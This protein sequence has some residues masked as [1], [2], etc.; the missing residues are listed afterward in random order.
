MVRS[1]P[2]EDTAEI[3]KRLIVGL[4]KMDGRWTLVYEHHSEPSR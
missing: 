2:D 4:V 3:R 1:G